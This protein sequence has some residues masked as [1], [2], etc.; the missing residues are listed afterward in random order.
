MED[1]KVP[2]ATVVAEVTCSDGRS[3]RGRVFVP[4]SSYSH[5]GPMR[6]EEWLNE[7]PAF[8]AILP[9]EVDAPL[10]LNKRELL[11]VTVPAASNLE[12]GE[13]QSG[14]PRRQV[15]VETGGRRVE[16]TIDIETPQHQQRVLD[17]LNRPEPFL[18]LRDGERHHLVYK[19]RIIRLVEVPES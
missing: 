2:M 8:F 5:E 19:P 13:D 11:V 4:A 16:G 10:I 9:E 15:V 6:A 14:R 3:I 12:V 7:P 1:L 17:H 18:T